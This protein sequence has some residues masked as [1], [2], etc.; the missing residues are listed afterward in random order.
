MW[1]CLEIVLWGIFNL[2]QEG[3]SS[4]HRNQH[5]SSIHH[6]HHS[7]FSNG[8]SSRRNSEVLPIGLRLWKQQETT[9]TQEWQGE[10]TGSVLS[11][12]YILPKHPVFSQAPALAC[13]FS[14]LFPE[15]HHVSLLSKTFSQGQAWWHTWRQR[16]ADF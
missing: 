4:V 5:G 8:S 6:E 14:R 9:R 16:Q 12:I 15:K 2:C 1:T 13:P 7:Q 10:P 3:S 11:Y